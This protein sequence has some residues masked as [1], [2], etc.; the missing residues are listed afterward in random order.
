MLCLNGEIKKYLKYNHFFEVFH[1]AKLVKIHIPSKLVEFEFLLT[2]P[3][4]QNDPNGSNGLNDQ[5]VSGGPND[6]NR[7]GRPNDPHGPGRP[8]NLEVSAGSTT[9]TCQAGL[10]TVH[11]RPVQRPTWARLT[12]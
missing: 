1:L 2:Q 5:D 3:Y 12:Q 11:A 4:P 10:T 8:N 7:S 9:Q 6:P